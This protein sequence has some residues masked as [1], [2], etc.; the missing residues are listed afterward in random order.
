MAEV[1]EAWQSGYAERLIRTIK[2]KEVDLSDYVDYREA[3][4]RLSC[5]LDEVYT[6]ECIHSSLGYLP[7]AEFESEWLAE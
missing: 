1:G 6:H 3:C 4:Q 7:R 5:F 2:E